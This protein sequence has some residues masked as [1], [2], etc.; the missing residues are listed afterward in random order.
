M[1]E[2]KIVVDLEKCL[3]VGTE[4]A[5]AAGAEI[6]AGFTDGRAQS[7]AGWKGTADLVTDVD[8]RVEKLV[9]ERLREAFPGYGFIGEETAG[10]NETVTDLPTWVVDPIDGTSNCHPSFRQKPSR[11]TSH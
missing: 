6:L 11:A 7:T 2:S 9:F 5:R 4:V 8:R 10:S 1:T 3:S